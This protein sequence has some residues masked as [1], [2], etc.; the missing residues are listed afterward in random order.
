MGEAV[1]HAQGK[2]TLNSETL[3][4]PGDPP[5]FTRS[6]IKAIREK[7]NM[8]QPVFASVLGCSPDSV[9]SWESRGG[10]RPNRTSRRLIQV[11]QYNPMAIFEATKKSG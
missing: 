10:N 3:E 6:E 4:I 11:L 1:S 2:I 5:E 9:K 8:S 7:L